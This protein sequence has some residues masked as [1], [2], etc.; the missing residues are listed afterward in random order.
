MGFFAVFL[1]P[2]HN[3][4]LCFCG[5]RLYIKLSNNNLVEHMQSHYMVYIHCV[6]ACIS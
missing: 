6:F 5:I 4:I 1:F 3:T 2:M